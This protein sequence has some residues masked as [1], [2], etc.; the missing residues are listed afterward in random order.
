MTT[1]VPSSPHFETPAD[2]NYGYIWLIS[3]VAAMGG[4]RFGWDWVVIGGAMPFSSSSFTLMTMP[5]CPAGPI[6]APSSA[7]LSEH[8]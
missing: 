2:S 4:L 3:I 5:H 1:A 6:A 8:W 7:A